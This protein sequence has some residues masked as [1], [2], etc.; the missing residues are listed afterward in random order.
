MVNYAN[1]VCR[2]IAESFLDEETIDLVGR[3]LALEE[4]ERVKSI[5]WDIG[6]K[7]RLEGK[8]ISRINTTINIIKPFN[9][10]QELEDY[11]RAHNLP[12]QPIHLAQGTS[13]NTYYC[14][15]S[16]I[17][18]DLILEVSFLPPGF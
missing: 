4:D 18:D 5:E 15:E 6:T 11:L 10:K 16:Q 12:T 8:Y 17:K 2:K 9:T 14:L 7:N 3:V 13:Q 1:K